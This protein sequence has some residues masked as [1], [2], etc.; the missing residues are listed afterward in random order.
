MGGQI[1]VISFVPSCRKGELPEKDITKMVYK[2]DNRRFK[3]K[4][5][6]KLKRNWQ[7]WKRKSSN[8]SSSRSR[9]LEEGVMLDI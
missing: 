9:N 5:L 8:T 2:W 1:L 6:K 4:Y 3:N 7:R